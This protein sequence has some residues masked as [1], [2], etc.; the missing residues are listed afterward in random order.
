MTDSGRVG[1]HEQ[2]VRG[3]L[4]EPGRGVVEGR[5]V[6]QVDD[7]VRPIQRFRQAPP[8]QEVQTRVRRL[9]HGFVA[10]R[11]QDADYLRSDE[12]GPTDDGDL[13]VLDP[14]SR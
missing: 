1:G 3:L 2:I 6:R 14:S 4:E 9:R 7:N 12:P 13:H 5:R 8:A 10:A 11:V